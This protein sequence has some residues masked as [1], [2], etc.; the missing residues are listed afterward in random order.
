M[1]SNGKLLDKVVAWKTGTQTLGSPNLKNRMTYFYFITTFYQYS[2][3]IYQHFLFLKMSLK[4]H[5][6]CVFVCWY[7]PLCVNIY[8]LT[9]KSHT[10]AAESACLSSCC[11]CHWL[12]YWAEPS[13]DCQG[14]S[15]ACAYLLPS[16]TAAPGVRRKR[17]MIWWWHTFIG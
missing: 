16:L 14:W 1:E 15:A 10:L 11:P 12:K 8:R 13:V 17:E 2:K 4:N 5:L 9:S 3:Q 6:V 7:F